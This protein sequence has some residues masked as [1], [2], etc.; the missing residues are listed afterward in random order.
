MRWAHLDHAPFRLLVYMAIVAQD[1]GDPPMFYQGQEACAMALGMP[2]DADAK[3]RQAAFRGVRRHI[4][5]LVKAKCIERTFAG[6]PGRNAEYALR[7]S[8]DR[9]TFT[10]PQSEDGERPPSEPE[11]RTLS[12]TNGGRSAAQRRTVG[13]TT[14]D[15]H[16]PPKE[17]RTT[18]L[19]TRSEVETNVDGSPA[20]VGAL[21]RETKP[22]KC[23]PC[24]TVHTGL[25]CA[26][27]RNGDDLMKGAS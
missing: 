19:K 9:R 24:G 4:D 16:R 13:G 27:Y 20:R 1:N 15:A 10:D 6:A 8:M 22:R 2:P 3:A 17:D 23:R 26:Q 14:A 12:A 21:A 25:T 5:Y 7:L 18:G 11:R